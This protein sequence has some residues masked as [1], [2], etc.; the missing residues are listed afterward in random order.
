MLRTNYKD[1]ILDSGET[2]RRYELVENQDNT[3]S[4]VDVTSYQ[5]NGDTFGAADINAT[6]TAVNKCIDY[7]S[8]TLPANTD[9]VTVTA[10]ND[11]LDFFNA[12]SHV[13]VYVPGSKVQA[14]VVKSTS[15]TPQSGSTPSSCTVVFSSTVDSASQIDVYSK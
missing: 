12:N 8:A 7:V 15:I 1:D 5:Q 11:I 9:N 6:N 10:P 13:E 4:L 2:R 3:V 14:L